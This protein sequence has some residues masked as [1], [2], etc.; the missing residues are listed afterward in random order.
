MSVKIEW[1]IFTAEARS[2]GTWKSN[3]PALAELLNAIAGQ[4]KIREPTLNIEESMA[5]LAIRGLPYFKITES[6]SET[7]G[8]KNFRNLHAKNTDSKVVFV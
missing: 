1:Q 5:R 6:T 3:S 8:G 7:P 4:E 2:N